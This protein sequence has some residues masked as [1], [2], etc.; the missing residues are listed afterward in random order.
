MKAPWM[1]APRD[2]EARCLAA[3]GQLCSVLG[4]T[5]LVVAAALAVA[6][7]S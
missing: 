3:L 6:A 7:L 4:A 2:S 1:R 5:L